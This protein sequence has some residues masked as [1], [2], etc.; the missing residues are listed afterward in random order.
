MVAGAPK[1][2]LILRD[3]WQSALWR[4]FAGN[5]LTT[6]QQFLGSL[7]SEKVHSEVTECADPNGKLIDFEGPNDP[8]STFNWSTGYKSVILMLTS[9]AAFVK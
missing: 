8:M 4:A 7:D 5:L 9:L 1:A 3:Y 2:P 6:S